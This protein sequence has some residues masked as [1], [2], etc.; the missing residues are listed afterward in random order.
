VSDLHD[1][2]QSARYWQR[3]CVKQQAEIERLK[4]VVG[5]QRYTLDAQRK[6][7][8]RV[9]AVVDAVNSVSFILRNSVVSMTQSDW[10]TIVD[11][12]ENAA[13]EGEK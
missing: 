4:K 11:A 3:K 8:E 12:V 10:E 6:E 1:I 2:E 9:Q 7:T 13:L 5:N